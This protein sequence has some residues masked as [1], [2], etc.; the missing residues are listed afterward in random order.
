MKRRARR[1][2]TTRERKLVKGV[3]AGKSR[4]QAAREA[5]YSE[6]TAWKSSAAILER[7]IVRSFLTEALK[8]AGL[9]PRTIIQPLVEALAA[10]ARTSY[11]GALIEH[12]QPDHEIRLEAYDRISAAFGAIPQR[13]EMPD[14]PKPSL[15]V[16]IIAPPGVPLPSQPA[17]IE[18][19]PTQ[20][21]HVEDR[22]TLRVNLIPPVPPKGE[23]RA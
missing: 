20:I 18:A 22:T 10:K 2:L 14:A 1:K 16:N 11:Q 15:T 9:T 19:S 23:G 3:L 21:T 13:V 6:T 8:E 5:G 7:P 4:T 17:T 12:E